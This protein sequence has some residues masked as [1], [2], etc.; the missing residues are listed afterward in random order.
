MDYSYGSG[1][2]QMVGY[3]QKDK[4]TFRFHKMWRISRLAVKLLASQEWPCTTQFWWHQNKMLLQLFDVRFFLIRI[5]QTYL[6][7]QQTRKQ[8][9]RMKQC[10]SALLHISVHYK[11]PSGSLRLQYTLL[12]DMWHTVYSWQLHQFYSKP[13]HVPCEILFSYLSKAVTDCKLIWGN[14][15]I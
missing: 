10:V 12:A 13:K 1:S 9:F 3:H 6:W 4:Q 2:Q 11:S 7:N 15:V 5:W 8:I 14:L